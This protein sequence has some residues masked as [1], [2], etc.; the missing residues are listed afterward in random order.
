MGEKVGPPRPS[1]R[2]SSDG[3]WSLSLVRQVYWSS[4]RKN[5]HGIIHTNKL[6]PSGRLR[7][8]QEGRLS[9]GAGRLFAVLAPLVFVNKTARGNRFPPSPFLLASIYLL[10]CVCC[11]SGVTSGEARSY[12]VGVACRVN[13][14]IFPAGG[15]GSSSPS[16]A[17]I[18]K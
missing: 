11:D 15:E 9:M 10:L 3:G 6:R 13:G 5:T 8:P 14:L 7:E 17:P 12:P 1:H 18:G 4:W 2:Q 16:E